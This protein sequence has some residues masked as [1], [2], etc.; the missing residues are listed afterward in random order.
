MTSI[1]Y[2]N[3]PLYFMRRFFIPVRCCSRDSSSESQ[4][5]LSP[6]RPRSLSSSASNPSAII[7]PSWIFDGS[8]S[9]RAEDRKFCRLE[10][11]AI[12]DAI[13]AHKLPASTNCLFM[14]PICS[15]VACIADNSLGLR[16]L[17]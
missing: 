7:P 8:S 11:S 6:E 4:A 13:S 3:A 17:F 14:G 5:R 1:K 9:D 12:F 16:S 2:P 10:K 15:S